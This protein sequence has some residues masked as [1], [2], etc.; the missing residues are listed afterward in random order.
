MTLA[1]Y[2]FYN[3]TYKTAI[4]Y[5]CSLYYNITYNLHLRNLIKDTPKLKDCKRLEIKSIF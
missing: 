2:K 1:Y 4:N 5:I 3:I